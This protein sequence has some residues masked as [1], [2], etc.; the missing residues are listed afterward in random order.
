[1]TAFHQKYFSLF[2]FLAWGIFTS[3]AQTNS[4]INSN[5]EIRNERSMFSKVFLKENGANEA[6]ISSAPVHYKKNGVWEEIDTKI[7]SSNIGYQNE[8]NL[9][10]S[11][12]PNNISGAGKI[13][14]VVN[15]GDEL[16]IHSE[17]KLV[18]VNDQG[19]I[20]ILSVN[21]NSSTANVS[22][23]SINYSGIYKGIS[24]EFTILNGKIKN[25]II[26]NTLPTL[27]NDV[28]SGY[29]GFREKIELPIGWKII[30]ELTSSALQIIDSKN[31]PILTIPEPVFFDNYGLQLDGS[32]MIE[33]KYLVK[34]ENDHWTITT[35]VPVNWLKDVNTKYPVSIDPTVL[36]TGVNGGWQSP[37][38]WVD[39][40][41]F[42]FI[43][44]C[45]ANLT[46][47]AWIL[48]NTT[49]I[50]DA[51]CITAVEL[52]VNVGSVAN[53]T[54]ELVLINDVTGAPGP[55]GAI[56]PAA[57]NDFGTG[58]YTTFTI[59]G[60]GIYGYYNLGAAANTLLQSQLPLN[61]FQ[62]AFQFNNEP[63]TNYK[64]I[65][66]TSSNLRITYN[67]PPCILPIE[68]LSFDARCN[69]DK[70]NLNWETASQTNNDHFT[71]E[72]TV[73]GINYET[74]GTIAG[75]GNS[76]KTIN[77]SFVDEKPLEGTSYYSLKQTDF[78]GRSKH[79]KLVPVSCIAA[80]E[81]AISPNP[82]NGKFIIENAEQ[83]SDII[84]TDV[85]GQIVFQTKIVT[86]KNEIDLSSNFN[87]IYFIHTVSK[88]GLVSKKIIISK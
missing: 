5:L 46:H 82:S 45:C 22:N 7:I 79:F 41:G 68:L 27:L 35:L 44:V 59:N 17:K 71:I 40:P 47:R 60:A 13:K 21:S 64:I 61:W 84:I 80:I 14:L 31:V 19:D 11:Y 85:F 8:S 69:N 62:V 38:N 12:F 43:G 77:Y 87:G 9:L 63:S 16:F 42:V 66:A 88:S 37:N 36:L 74:V 25:N 78:N 58:L 33:G 48:Y 15:E 39:N 56:T 3:N 29:F 28:S 10:R 72:R 26:L 50:P 34:Q 4:A 65:N 67:A 75:A 23:N 76:N 83:N 54:P 18:L 20:N 49:T 32:N 53:N 30:P 24:D 73:D 6:I 2:T 57:Y 86:E 55:Y 1:M 51:S 70:V 81:L 52:E